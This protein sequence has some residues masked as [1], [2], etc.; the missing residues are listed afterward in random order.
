MIAFVDFVAVAAFGH[1]EWARHLPRSSTE[2]AIAKLESRDHHGTSAAYGRHPPKFLDSC[3][4][5][6]DSF[7]V[8]S[9]YCPADSEFA[10][11][12]RP[13]LKLNLGEEG[14]SI[15]RLLLQLFRLP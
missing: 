3:L 7:G 15:H 9:S 2:S 8:F 14:G 11:R 12:N 4:E 6:S 13:F 5:P 10:Q 1:Q